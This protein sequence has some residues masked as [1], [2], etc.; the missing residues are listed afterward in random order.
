MQDL[1]DKSDG[2]EG[3]ADPEALERRRLAEAEEWRLQQLRSGDADAN[4]NM[5]VGC[6]PHPS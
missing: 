4:P 6:V 1:E 2:E 3:P 5:Q